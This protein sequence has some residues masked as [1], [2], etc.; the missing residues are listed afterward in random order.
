VRRADLQL[1]ALNSPSVDRAERADRRVDR[2]GRDTG[3]D[4]AVHEVLQVDTPNA[5]ER[6][7]AE[8]RVDA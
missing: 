4:E 3:S 8:G 6:R 7:G 1:V 5:V 2:R